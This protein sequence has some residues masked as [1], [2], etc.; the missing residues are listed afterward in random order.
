M[1]GKDKGEIEASV[2]AVVGC[3]YWIGRICPCGEMDCYGFD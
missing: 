3:G 2:A 1:N